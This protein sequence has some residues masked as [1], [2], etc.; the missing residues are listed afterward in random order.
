MLYQELMC[1]CDQIHA[2]TL[3]THVGDLQYKKSHIVEDE[4]KDKICV[5]SESCNPKDLG[6]Y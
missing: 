3:S 2:L 5:K 6:T 1:I 4:R